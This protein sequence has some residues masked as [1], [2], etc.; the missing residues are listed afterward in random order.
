M[1]SRKLLLFSN[2]EIWVKKIIHILA[3][4]WEASKEQSYAS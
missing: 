4:L 1:H 3:L 2:N